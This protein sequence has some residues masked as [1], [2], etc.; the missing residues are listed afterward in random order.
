MFEA[1][2]FPSKV[3]NG[4]PVYVKNGPTAPVPFNQPAPDGTPPAN[5]PPTTAPPPPS[6][7]TTTSS[8]TT[9]APGVL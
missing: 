4:T 3:P 9:T 8:T 6:E 5:P 2:W 1:A 7:T